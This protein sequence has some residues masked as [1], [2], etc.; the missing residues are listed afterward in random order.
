MKIKP[1]YNYYKYAGLLFGLIF[2]S[3]LIMSKLHV[4]NLKTEDSRIF[5]L[6]TLIAVIRYNQLKV[7]HLENQIT[8]LKL[9]Y[10]GERSEVRL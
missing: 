1:T 6:L 4:L 9:K 8:E 7:K 5:S 3:I 2:I 10:E